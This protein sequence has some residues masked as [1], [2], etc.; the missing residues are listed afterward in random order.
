MVDLFGVDTDLWTAGAAVAQTIIVGTAAVFAFRQVREAQL[1]R[2]DQSRPFV[3]LDFDL[4]RPPFIQPVIRTS[5]SR[6]PAG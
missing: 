6:W 4:S 1:T 5:A 2:E 3:I